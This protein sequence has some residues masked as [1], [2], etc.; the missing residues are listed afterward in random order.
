MVK[1]S[2]VMEAW[3]ASGGADGARS[4]ATIVTRD[5]GINMGRWLAGKLMKELAI[6]SRRPT[7][8]NVVATNMLRYQ[9]ISTTS[10]Q[11]M[12]RIRSGAVM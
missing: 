2:Q 5:S 8:T 1:R 10:S 12:H 4:I 9:T 11:Y 6:A 3:N 7:N